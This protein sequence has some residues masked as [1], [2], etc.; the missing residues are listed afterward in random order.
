MTFTSKT[1]G[2]CLEALLPFGKVL[3]LMAII[4]TVPFVGYG[5]DFRKGYIIKSDKDTIRGLVANRSAKKNSEG[6]L[7]KSSNLNDA[8]EY[9]PLQLIGFGII[10]YRQYEAKNISIN[11]QERKFRFVEVIVK[12][13]LSL[14]KNQQIFYLEKDSIFQLEQSVS[15]QLSQR[16]KNNRYIGTLNYVMK[17]CMQNNDKVSYNEESLADAVMRYNQCKG[18]VVYEAKTKTPKFKFNGMVLTGLDIGSVSLQGLEKFSYAKSISLP[19]GIGL[20]INFPRFND[21]FFSL[22]E[23][24]YDKK[25]YQV[26]D[27]SFSNGSLSRS[28]FSVKF[29]YMKMP[30]GV[31]YNFAKESSTFYFKGGLI[32]YFMFD[33]SGI[34]IAENEIN[35]VVFK[36]LTSYN[37]S[38][39]NPGG[40]WLGGGYQRKISG[41]N[42]GFAEFRYELNSGF[43]N[44]TPG[45]K[46]I[47][48]NLTL[49]FGLIF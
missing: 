24:Y 12:G 36:D 1:I 39:R 23:L 30:L 35:G 41:S 28:D 31:Q 20:K 7:F 42:I 32:Y 38:I 26:Y 2:P 19:V 33:L 15:N 29:S 14:Y 11:H 34:V 16:V 9:T 46:S 5:Q 27:E 6:C 43:T 47:G 37:F 18:A 48:N 8:E 21:K 3:F 22:L 10:D 17:D 4:T 44:P 13:G 40:F 25:V 45:S 49:L